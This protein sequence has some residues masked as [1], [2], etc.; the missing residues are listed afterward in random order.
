MQGDNATSNHDGFVLV[1]QDGC[2]LC[3]HSDPE[4]ERELATLAQIFFEFYLSEYMKKFAPEKNSP[5]VDTDATSN[6]LK[7]R[8]SN[9]SNNP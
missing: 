1:H 5:S 9:Q 2:P 4:M 3:E 8:S 7:E 6:T